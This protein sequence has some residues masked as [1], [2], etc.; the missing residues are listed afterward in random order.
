MTMSPTI[1]LFWNKNWKIYNGV[2]RLGTLPSEILKTINSLYPGNIK[3][4]FTPK[5]N[6][7][8]KINDILVSLNGNQSD[9]LPI[10]SGGWFLCTLNESGK[11]CITYFKPV[12]TETKIHF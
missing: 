8:V 9:I 5:L 2:K 3:N 10:E 12:K 6:V 4:R 7:R 11:N 1:K